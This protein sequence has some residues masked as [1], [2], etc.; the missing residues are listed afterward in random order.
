VKLVFPEIN[1]NILHLN[2]KNKPSFLTRIIDFLSPKVAG[3]LFVNSQI[4]AFAFAK[5][6]CSDK[7]AAML[8][9]R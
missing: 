9:Q 2:N 7:L 1:E 8:V 6:S 4:G 3:L 5:I